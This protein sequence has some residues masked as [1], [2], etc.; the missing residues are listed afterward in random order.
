[1]ERLRERSQYS[2]VFRRGKA[3]RHPLLV[4]RALP[5][6]LEVSR[7]GL[8]VGRKVGKAVV[9]NKVRRRLRECLRVAPLQVGWD[10]VFISA[11]EAAKANY[12]ALD[13]A[14]QELLSR[15]GVLKETS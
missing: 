6:G 13:Q 15:A 9:R 1:M 2:R 4:L 7:T 14:V 8:V 3:F 11:P 12:Q 10:L 5:N